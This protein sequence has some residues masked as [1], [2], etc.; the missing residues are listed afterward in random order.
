MRQNRSFQHVYACLCIAENNHTHT[1]KEKNSYIESKKFIGKVKLKKLGKGHTAF[2]ITC[3]QI[4]EKSF[5]IIL[6]L[7]GCEVAARVSVV[8]TFFLVSWCCESQ[9]FHS[10]LS[11]SR[12]PWKRFHTYLYHSESVWW[13]PLHWTREADGDI[14]PSAFLNVDS[15]WILQLEATEV[16]PWNPNYT[17]DTVFYTGWETRCRKQR[18]V[19]LDLKYWPFFVLVLKYFRRWHRLTEL[20]STSSKAMSIQ[21]VLDIKAGLVQDKTSVGLSYD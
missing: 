5:Q 8:L 12:N 1:F 3:I 9:L 2:T 17:C 16:F 19:F 6:H 4:M 10:E 18:F 15:D 11:L 20:V 21:Q 13:T 7:R 14:P